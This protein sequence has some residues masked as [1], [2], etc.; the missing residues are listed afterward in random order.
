V[1]GGCRRDGL[2]YLRFFSLLLGDHEGL[3]VDGV[4]HAILDLE[5]SEGIVNFLSCELVTE[6][7]H[8]M[9][10]QISI[11]FALVL[12][13]I[14]GFDDGVVIIGTASHLLGEEDDH[15][16]EVDGSGGLGDHALGL[17]VGDGSAD[18]GEG[19]LQVA[20]GQDAILV[21]I[22]DTESLLELLDGTLGEHSEDIAAALLGFLGS[23]SPSHF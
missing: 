12:E 9:P 6:G 19:G 7:H 3:E 14:K 22:H 8:R 16:G 18:G 10:E 15:L 20:G 23:G 1:D 5:L 21:S 17:A 13:C 4:D 2:A 11:D